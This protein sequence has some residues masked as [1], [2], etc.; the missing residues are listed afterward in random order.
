MIYVRLRNILTAEEIEKKKQ[1]LKSWEGRLLATGT[2]PWAFKRKSLKEI[3]ERKSFS[4]T[5]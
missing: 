4:F 5:F 1:T 2:S 3:F